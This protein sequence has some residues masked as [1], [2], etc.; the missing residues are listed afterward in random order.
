MA[1]PFWIFIRFFHRFF[2]LKILRVFE[3][4]SMVGYDLFCK[5]LYFFIIAITLLR[6]LS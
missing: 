5:L 3:P 2:T 1:V 6:L 4:D